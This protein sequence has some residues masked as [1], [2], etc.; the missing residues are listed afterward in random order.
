MLLP[1]I[2]RNSK[3]TK[4][5]TREDHIIK[6]LSYGI[7]VINDDEKICLVQRK[8]SFGYLVCIGNNHELSD[9]TRDITETLATITTS[10]KD[11]ILTMSWDQLWSDC[12]PNQPNKRECEARFEWLGIRDTVKTLD[13]RGEK[14]QIDNEWSIPKGRMM[15]SDNGVPLRCALRELEE[16]TNISR[17][18]IDVIA[19]LGTITSEIV[20]TD[21]KCYVSMFYIGR[22][23]AMN[24]QET[25]N[26]EIRKVDWCTPKQCE[27]RLAPTAYNSIVDA[28]NRFR[29]NSD[30][31]SNC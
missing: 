8:D 30:C 13:Q 12:C 17:Y 20:G 5:R 2:I 31:Q 21:G 11:K 25:S 15:S 7:I 10:E 19:K 16:E 6:K 29:Q 23:K 18:N 4:K 1:N 9:G 24:N 14:W 22:L 28:L 27:E 3:I 26:N